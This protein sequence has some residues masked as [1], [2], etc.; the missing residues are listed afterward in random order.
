MASV[1]D[2]VIVEDHFEPT[3]V[4]LRTYIDDRYKLTVHQGRP[5][6]ELYDLHDDPGETANRFDDPAAASLRAHL[7]ERFL[8]AELRR[9]P[10]P[11][12]RVAS[13]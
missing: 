12:R 1:R 2:H 5:W 8:D 11:T 10:L 9:E 4:H 7:Y 3:S 6:G 13:A